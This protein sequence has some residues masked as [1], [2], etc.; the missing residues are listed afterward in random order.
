MNKMRLQVALSKAGIASRRKAAELI[1]S[2]RVK[3]NGRL[4]TEKGHPVDISKDKIT[5]DKKPV[6]FEKKYYYILNKPTGVLSAVS[7]QRKRK[8]VSDYVKWVGARLYPVGRLDKDT[9]GL[10][11][12]TNDGDF[13]YRLTHPKFGIERIYEVKVEGKLEEKDLLKLV[14]GIKIDGKESRA[15]KASFKENA[16]RY[17]TVI[18]SLLEGRKR[19]IRRMFDYLGNKVIELKRLSYGP[20]K[21]G[22]LK[23]GEVRAI[24]G[25][26]LARLKKCIKLS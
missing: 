6:I 14:K 9:T 8:T 16:P 3:V 7:D 22:D 20:L 2:N 5:F 4:V 19:E 17:T 12:L 11:I 24:S 1:K 18:L 26:E 21:L 15:K 13:T 10:I 25:A 23:K